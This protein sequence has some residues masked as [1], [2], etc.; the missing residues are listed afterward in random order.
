MQYCPL[1]IYE[2][3]CKHG[4]WAIQIKN[5]ELA[6]IRWAN[7]DGKRLR[8]DGTP[9]IGRAAIAEAMQAFFADFPDLALSMADLRSGGNQAVFLWTLQ[10][11]NSG[12]GGTGNAVKIAGWQNWRLSGDALIIEAAGGYDAVGYERQIRE[13][14]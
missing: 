12:P 13:G 2:R 3:N 7:G 1:F 10:G 8:I 9:V 11:T 6:V 5:D 14:L 4:C